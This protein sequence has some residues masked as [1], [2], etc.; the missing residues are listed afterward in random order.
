M[1]LAGT[2]LTEAA[3]AARERRQRAVADH[4]V[5]ERQAS[6]GP[7]EGREEGDRPRRYTRGVV[8]EAHGRRGTRRCR[9]GLDRQ[10]EAGMVVAPCE[11]VADTIN[12]STP[13]SA[14]LGVPL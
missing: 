7:A 12:V 8:A 5:V 4:E 11:S 14:W 9:R 6:D 1:P 10:L 2:T 3:A 13:M